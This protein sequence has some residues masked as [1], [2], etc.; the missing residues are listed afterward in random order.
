MASDPASPADGDIWYNGT[1]ARLKARIDGRTMTLGD[2]EV[3]S[4]VPDAGRYFTANTTPGT[5]TTTLAGVADRMNIYPFIPK[6]DFTADQLGINVT[7]AVASSNAKIV[8]YD[9]DINGRPDQRITETGNLDCSSTGAKTASGLDRIQEGQA[10]LARRPHQLDPDDLR[11]PALYV[12][13]PRHGRDRHHADEDPA[14]HAR[15]CHRRPGGLGVR[16][17]RSRDDQRAGHLAP[18]GLTGWPSLPP[19]AECGAGNRVMTSPDGITWTARLGRGQRWLASPGRRSWGCSAR[20]PNNGTGNRV[21]TS[22]SAYRYPYRSSE[23][24]QSPSAA[25]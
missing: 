14:A 20:W 13:E 11:L 1:G 4:L 21:M 18:R 24:W 12:A 25:G 23:P 5:T 16:R 8:V 19:A 10:V 3:P 15:L 7:T 2:D 9:S 17:H 22:V 6:F